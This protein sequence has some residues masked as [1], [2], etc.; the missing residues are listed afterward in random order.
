MYL[1]LKKDFASVE[2]K[3]F[4]CASELVEREDLA[5]RFLFISLIHNIRGMFPA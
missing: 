1:N 3:I 4:G 2:M 5:A